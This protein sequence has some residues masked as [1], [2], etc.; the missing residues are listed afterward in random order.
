[1]FMS[2]ESLCTASVPLCPLLFFFL[3]L[4]RYL[5]RECILSV[6]GRQLDGLLDSLLVQVQ[7]LLEVRVLGFE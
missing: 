1:M 3:Q 2:S 6:V 4:Q 5:E 7:L